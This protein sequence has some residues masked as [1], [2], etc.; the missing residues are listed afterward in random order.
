MGVLFVF[1]DRG[2]RSSAIAGILAGGRRLRLLVAAVALEPRLSAAVLSA[3]QMHTVVVKPDG[4]VWSWGTAVLGQLGD[5]EMNRGI[6]DSAQAK[7]LFDVQA[8]AAGGNHSLALKKDGT[9]WAWGDNFWGELGDGTHTTRDV[10]ARVPDLDHI[11]AIAAGYLHSMALG[12]DGTVWAWGDNHFGQLGTGTTAESR[13]PIRVHSL[14]NASAIAAGFFHS[15]AIDRS[16]RVWTWGQNTRGQLGHESPAAQTLPDGVEG[17]TD[18][19]A[20]AGGQF[21]TLALRRDGTVW[22]WGGDTFG[23]LGR[24]TAVAASFTTSAAE[25]QT[26]A[27]VASSPAS[28]P[29]DGTLTLTPSEQAF[30]AAAVDTFI[31]ADDLTPSGS[32]CGVVVFIDRQLAGAWGS[33]ARMYRSGPFRKGKPEQGYQLALT[34]REFFAVGVAATNEWSRKAHGKDFD[35]L[36]P[37]E[38]EAAL[39]VL[40]RGKAEL[41]DFDGK[42]FFEALLTITME[43]FFADPIYGGNRNK[44]GWKMVGYPGLPATYRDEIKTYFNKKYDK[45][46]HSI[47]DFS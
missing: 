43:G 16:G 42:Q 21:H 27:P 44:A 15:A 30:F 6:S 31:P 47:A 3:G 4:S 18:A 2:G 36:A 7:D 35:R 12:A 10:P 13:R 28:A 32:D 24:G 38:R 37:K 23:Q 22:S 46:P 26:K 5:G 1:A 17:V 9:V 39:K 25:A 14:S 11:V 34:P 8:V 29:V 41:A 33:G 20:V 40:E 19:V 45:P